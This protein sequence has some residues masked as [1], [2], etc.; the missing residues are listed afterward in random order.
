MT[1]YR[2]VKWWEKV[3]KEDQYSYCEGNT[4]DLD[5]RG[6][7][8]VEGRSNGAVGNMYGLPLFIAKLRFRW[9]YYKESEPPY[10]RRKR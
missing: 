7:P 8:S 2:L 6:W 5:G 10:I 9:L 1:K 4:P 3:G